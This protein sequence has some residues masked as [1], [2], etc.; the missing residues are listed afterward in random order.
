ML[1]LHEVLV[2]EVKNQREGFL[3]QPEKLEIVDLQQMPD[4]KRSNIL[5]YRLADIDILAE[6]SENTIC[7]ECCDKN[8]VFSELPFKRQGCASFFRLLLQVVWLGAQILYV[9][10]NFF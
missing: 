7:K 10:K 1:R 9:K 3:P 5:G 6:V 8:L 2:S 4:G